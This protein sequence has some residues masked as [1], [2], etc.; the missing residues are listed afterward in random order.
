MVMDGLKMACNARVDR[1][2]HTTVM[3]EQPGRLGVVVLTLDFETPGTLKVQSNSVLGYRFRSRIRSN[4]YDNRLPSTTNRH[5]A[6]SGLSVCS[7]RFG[8]QFAARDTS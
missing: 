6:A 3:S 8:L 1:V 2:L 4:G 7:S 5:R